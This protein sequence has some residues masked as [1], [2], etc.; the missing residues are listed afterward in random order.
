MRVLSSPE[1][2]TV[3]VAH[4]NV[5]YCSAVWCEEDSNVSRVLVKSQHSCQ[6]ITEYLQINLVETCTPLE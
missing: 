5:K 4:S 6:E 1:A 3:L 2:N